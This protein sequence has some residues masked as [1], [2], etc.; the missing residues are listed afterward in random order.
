VIRLTLLPVRLAVLPLQLMAAL[1][2]GVAW[3][4]ATFGRRRG[5]VR[6]CH[7]GATT[8]RVRVM[9]GQVPMGPDLR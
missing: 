6:S 5:P 7:H 1:V 9:V 3:S 2:R 8:S 4:R